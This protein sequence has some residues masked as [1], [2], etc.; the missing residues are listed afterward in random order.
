V[1]ESGDTLVHK[2]NAVPYIGAD[3]PKKH[4]L[5]GQDQLDIQPE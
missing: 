5:V 3:Q 4:S 1:E 2:T